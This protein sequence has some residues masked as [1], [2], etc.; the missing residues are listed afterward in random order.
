MHLVSSRPSLCSKER[1]ALDWRTSG[2][3]DGGCAER[4]RGVAEAER[5]VCC[6]QGRA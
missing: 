2:S 6:V 3:S 5:L 4:N 1:V